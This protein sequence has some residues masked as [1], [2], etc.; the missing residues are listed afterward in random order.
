MLGGKDIPKSDTKGRKQKEK[1]KSLDL[2]RENQF[3]KH[4]K[5]KTK[6]QGWEKI[7]IIYDK[8]LIFSV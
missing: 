8:G 2:M 3:S 5:W 1:N 7:C 4:F 6:W